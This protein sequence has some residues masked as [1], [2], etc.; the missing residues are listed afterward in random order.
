MEGVLHTVHLRVQHI[1]RAAASEVMVNFYSLGGTVAREIA[2]N[3]LW[4]SG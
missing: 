4:G 3:Q 2:S 1:H